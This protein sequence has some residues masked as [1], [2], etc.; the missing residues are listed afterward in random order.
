M[1]KRKVVLVTGSRAEYGILRYVIKYLKESNFL[2]LHLIVTGMHL[3]HE[4]GNTYKEIENDGILINDKV[5]ILLSGDSPTSISKSIALGI[6]SFSEIFEKI[7]PDFLLVLGDRFEIISASISATVSRIPI[8]HIHGGETTEGVIDESIRHSITKMSH[9]HFPSTEEYMERVIQ[10]GEDPKNVYNFGSPAIDSIFNLNLVKKDK[11]E[12]L[13][14][15]KITEKYFIVTFHPVTL[16]NFSAQNQFMELL[17]AL[18]NFNSYKIIFTYPNSDMNG[19]IIIEMIEEFIKLNKL[20]SISFK[21][22]GQLKYFSLLKS[23]TL[24]IGNSSSGLIEAPSFKIPTINIG[25]RQ[26]GRVK[27]K[28]VIDCSPTKKS[29]EQAIKKGI[30][31]QFRECLRELKNPYGFK[32]ASKK[33]VNTLEKIKF[34]QVILKKKFHDL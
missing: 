30:S 10:L 8:V 18:K 27:A 4:F 33:I 22:L 12:K 23:A 32:G 26:R 6:I 1:N 21:S 9:I 7:K 20:N 14:N 24:V 11:L 5:E 31:K 17:L 25:D 2:D 29:I 16:E 34:D 3:S 13:I 19:R 28:S 15:F